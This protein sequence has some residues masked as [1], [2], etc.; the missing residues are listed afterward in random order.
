MKCDFN[1]YM[2]LFVPLY[3]P[4][5]A[6]LKRVVLVP[7]HGPRPRPKPGPTLKYFVSCRAWA[8]LFF[9]LRAGPSGPAQMYTYSRRSKGSSHSEHLILA[10]TKGDAT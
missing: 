9:V 6:C 10:R 3:G 5:R 1:K 7:A 2:G 8:V 4:F